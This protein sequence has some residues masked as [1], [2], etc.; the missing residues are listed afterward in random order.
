VLEHPAPEGREANEAPG[1]EGSE[2]TLAGVS[3]RKE[4]NRGEWVSLK[5]AVVFSARAEQS[6]RGHYRVR[7]CEVRDGRL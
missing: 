6:E 2:E 4:L 5:Y 1:A 3:G 7:W